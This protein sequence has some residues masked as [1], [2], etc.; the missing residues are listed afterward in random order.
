MNLLRTALFALALFAIFSCDKAKAPVDPDPVY[1]VFVK[2]DYFEI[3]ARYALFLSNADGETVAFRWLPSED[4]AHVQVPG[5]RPED[6]FDCTILK[7]I[8]LEAPGSGVKDTSLTLT[9]YTNL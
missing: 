4:T 8:T 5:S 6:R 9:T 1:E 3:Q 2:N 7:V